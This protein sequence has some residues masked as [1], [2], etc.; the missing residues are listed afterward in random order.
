MVNTST[1]ISIM[2]AFIVAETPLIG[3]VL[4]MSNRI[5]KLETTIELLLVRTVRHR[6]EDFIDENKQ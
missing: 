4:H 6:K 2:I 3:M 5:V 1:L